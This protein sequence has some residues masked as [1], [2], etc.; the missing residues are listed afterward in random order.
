[1]FSI[2]TERL[3]IFPLEKANLQLSIR[4]FSKVEGALG[5][6]ISGK[7]LSDRETKVYEIR[8][9]A[10]ESNQIN[11]RWN[12]VWVIALKD[13]NR[14]IGT[15]MIKNY[16]NEKG[17]VIIGY[18]IEKEYRG[19]GFM[20]E[21]LNGLIKWMSL[22]PEVK[23][24]IA[25]TLKDNIPSQRG[26]Q[27]IGMIN[28]FEDEE[29]LWWRLTM[30]RNRAFSAI[31]NDGK[32]AMVKHERSTSS[33]WTLPG[34]G[35]EEGEELEEAAIR[36]AKE[37]VNLKITI[38]RPL[39]STEYTKGTEYCFLAIPSEECELKLGCDPEFSDDD[40]IL[41]EAAWID[42]SCVCEDKQVSKVLEALT[43]EEMKAFKIVL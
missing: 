2:S 26:L 38:I 36:E 23:A 33:F 21:A 28:Y 4:D 29:C 39:F 35:V 32:I 22:N 34:G 11:Y 40:Q 17:E 6:T 3:K 25:D 41:K 16:P 30:K 19:M 43:D 27:K 12:T 9:E 14:F 5:L 20:T 18:S 42:V 13:I 7:K 1:M 24:V 37:E 10:V 31:I 15:I 8:L